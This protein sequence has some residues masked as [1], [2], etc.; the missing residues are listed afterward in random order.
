[1]KNIFIFGFQTGRACKSPAAQSGLQKASALFFVQMFQR[2]V[3][4]FAEFTV[5]EMVASKKG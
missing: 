4:Q 1:M 5:Q 2:S 3:P